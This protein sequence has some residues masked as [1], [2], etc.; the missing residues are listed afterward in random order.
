MGG[1]KV[2]VCAREIDLLPS[3][4]RHVQEAK[5]IKQHD[6][7]VPLLL[8]IASLMYTAQLHLSSQG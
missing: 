3:V 4:G 5:Q 8:T 6:Y 7:C 2:S 1:I